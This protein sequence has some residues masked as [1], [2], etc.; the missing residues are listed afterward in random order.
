MGGFPL[1]PRSPAVASALPRF[2][3]CPPAFA[4][5]PILVT[6]DKDYINLYHVFARRNCKFPVKKRWH[7]VRQ[8]IGPSRWKISVVRNRDE[9]PARELERN[10]DP[11]RGRYKRYVDQLASGD[12]LSLHSLKEAIKAR[13]AWQLYIPKAAR[14][15]LRSSV[16]RIPGK[17]PTYLVEITARTVR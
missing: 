6:S 15:H 3:S 13:R 1:P 7:L 4:G 2:V 11:K 16:R 17:I 5:R 14:R 12:K 10:Y 8:Q 9:V